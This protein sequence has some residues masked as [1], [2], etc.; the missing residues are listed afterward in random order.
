MVLIH[1]GTAISIPEWRKPSWISPY[2]AVTG[3]LELSGQTG[4]FNP[5]TFPAIRLIKNINFKKR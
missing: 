4:Q 3:R 5:E 1:D 2:A